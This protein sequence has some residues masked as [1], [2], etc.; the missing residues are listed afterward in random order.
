MHVFNFMI[1]VLCSMLTL[2]GPGLN[3]VGLNVAGPYNAKIHNGAHWR[4]EMSMKLGYD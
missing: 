3:K 2:P 1:P 4:P